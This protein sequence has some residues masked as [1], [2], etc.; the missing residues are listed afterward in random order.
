[1]TLP[2]STVSAFLN[3]LAAKT[4][5]PGG[6]AAACLTGATA[7]SLAHMVVAFSLGR[8]SLVEHQPALEAASTKLLALRDDFTRLAD[9]DAQ[10]Y[11]ALNAAMK[12]PADDPARAATLATSARAATDVPQRALARALDLLRLAESLRPITNPY[13]RSDLAIAAV[14]ADA[15]A[16]ASR[17]N[18]AINAPTLDE[19]APGEGSAALQAAERACADAAALLESI[20]TQCA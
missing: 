11:G 13:L 14:L 6:G 19:A 8:K 16:R 1:M 7:A 20:E 15:A 2:A 9:E 18:I 17:W 10:A 12:L 5:T 3:D 4:A